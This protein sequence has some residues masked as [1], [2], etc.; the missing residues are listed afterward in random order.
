MPK[1]ADSTESLEGVVPFLLDAKQAKA[2][3]K[4]IG[5]DEMASCA[6]NGDE[7]GRTISVPNGT[8]FHVPKVESTFPT[9]D[10]LMPS[11]D[12]SLVIG[13]NANYL[14]KL[15]RAFS[16]FQSEKRSPVIKLSFYGADKS[17]KMVKMEAEN[18]AGQTITALLMP[19]RL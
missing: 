10:A 8:K 3:G 4:S 9:V 16:Q 5:K 7:G 12:P 13:L 17:V 19:E 1:V 11:G 15:A 2:I 14:M 6:L 18:D